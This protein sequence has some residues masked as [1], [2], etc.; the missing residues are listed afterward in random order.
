MPLVVDVAVIAR[1]ARARGRE[2]GDHWKV[3]VRR[4][5]AGATQED[6]SG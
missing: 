4:S 5:G 6:M 3:I 1:T 2:R